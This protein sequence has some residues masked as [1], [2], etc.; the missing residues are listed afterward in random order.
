[1]TCGIY[2]IRNKIT[3]NIYIGSSKNIEKR[4]KAHLGNSNNLLMRNAYSD[5]GRKNFEFTILQECEENVLLQL[6]Q[7][8]IDKLK[9][10]Y[11]VERKVR[12]SKEERC[13][14]AW[15]NWLNKT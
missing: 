8:Y 3:N 7:E 11:N 6:E 13:K 5:Y 10:T 1:M 14:E 9:P 15:E 12:R 2:Q 4:W